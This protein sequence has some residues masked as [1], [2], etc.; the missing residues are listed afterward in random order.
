[1]EKQ[2][3]TTGSI[4]SGVEKLEID[5]SIIR[6]VDVGEI[7]GAETT[8]EM[9]KKVLR[10]LDWI[11]IPLMGGCYMLQYIDKLAIS[12]A[13]LFNLRQ[14]LVCFISTQCARRLITDSSE[15]L[16]GT[17]Y[18]WASAIFYFGYFAWSW[19][20]HC[21]SFTIESSTDKSCSL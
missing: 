5:E 18:N 3:P 4:R 12:Q 21:P 8:P 7:L 16:K 13:T 14:D 17:E 10:K 15:N 6:D 2:Q 1:M 11:L 20:E 9:A 19:Y